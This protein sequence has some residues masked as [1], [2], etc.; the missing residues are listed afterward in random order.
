MVVDA[1][2]VLTDMALIGPV[3]VVGKENMH[4]VSSLNVMHAQLAIFQV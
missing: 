2:N 4:L 3:L 1:P